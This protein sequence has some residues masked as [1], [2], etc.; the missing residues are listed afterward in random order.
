MQV[1]AK[2]AKTCMQRVR[3][4][5]DWASILNTTI[6]GWSGCVGRV[7]SLLPSCLPC[8]PQRKK[9]WPSSPLRSSRT[10]F[11]KDPPEEKK[12]GKLSVPKIEVVNSASAAAAD[13]ANSSPDFLE[14]EAFFLFFFQTCPFP[15]VYFIFS[16]SVF[17][18]A[19]FEGKNSCW[20][21]WMAGLEWMESSSS[22][23]S[24]LFF[25]A[26][27]GFDSLFLSCFF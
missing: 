19:D 8:P 4:Y 5:S 10:V 21:I 7:P 12:E 9:K 13:L 24:F 11:F 1:G 20:E 15:H 18:S 27:F 14:E 26:L 2:C 3:T 6:G 17:P 23:F 25:F 16:F 22:L